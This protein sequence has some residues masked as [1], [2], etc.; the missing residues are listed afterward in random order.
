MILDWDDFQKIPGCQEGNCTDIKE[1]GK[2]FLGG[3][4]LRDQ[5]SEGV[6]L[7]SIDDFNRAQSATGAEAAAPVLDRLRDVMI[8]LG[9]D[10]ELFDQVVDGMKREY[11]AS[12]SSEDEILTAVSDDLGESIFYTI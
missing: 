11:A 6:K 10:K 9:I 3:T 4:D 8:E 2:L 1:D 12:A 7:K 5:A